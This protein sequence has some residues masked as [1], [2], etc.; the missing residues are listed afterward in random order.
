MRPPAIERM[1]YYPTDE[2]VV[3]IIRTFVEPPTEKGGYLIP[4][5]AKE[6][7]RLL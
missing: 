6:K 2:P 1:G 4:A 5:R 3:Q 7:P